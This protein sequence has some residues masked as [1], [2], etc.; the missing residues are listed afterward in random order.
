MIGY[1]NVPILSAKMREEVTCEVQKSEQ[2]AL[3][4]VSGWSFDDVL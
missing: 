4:F 3:F 1:L 2:N